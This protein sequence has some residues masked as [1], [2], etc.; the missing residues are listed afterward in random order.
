MSSGGQALQ[1]IASILRRRFR[2]VCYG[3]RPTVDVAM[4]HTG[5][6]GS[7]VIADLIGQHPEVA[8]AGE[9]FEPFMHEETSLTG[10]ALIDDVISNQRAK[11][12]GRFFGFE[13]KYLAQQHLSAGC[14]G[15][16]IV[17]Y[18]GEL[19]H[20]GFSKFIV[21]HRKNYLRR[22]L[23]AAVGRHTNSWHSASVPSRP[24]KVVLDL[25]RFPT[26][27]ATSPL[28]TLFADMDAAYQQL[29][30][31]LGGESPLLLT[32]ESDVESDPLDAY[33][34]LV[35]FLGVPSANP[36]VRLQK[37]NPFSYEDTVSNWNEVVSL[38]SGT[39]YEWML[40]S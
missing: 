6:C 34:K 20:L 5:R 15:M 21:L 19:K 7:T 8:W 33:N 4:F 12:R 23:S 3:Q 24:T 32:Y 10:A 39:P 17:P 1:G 14:I 13:T 25:E 30:D 29:L 36:I 11:A 28:L 16:P 31:G 38:L 18:V 37:S 22:A 40:E 9:L 2:A 26:G 35:A 27:V